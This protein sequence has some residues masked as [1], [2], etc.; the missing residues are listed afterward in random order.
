MNRMYLELN[1]NRR[2]GRLGATVPWQRN[3]EW[4]AI[5]EKNRGPLRLRH[6]SA[7]SIQLATSRL[8]VYRSLNQSAINWQA[9]RQSG[10]RTDHRGG[11]LSLIHRFRFLGD[12]GSPLP[13]DIHFSFG[14]PT[15]LIFRKTTN[16]KRD[17]LLPFSFSPPFFVPTALFS[18]FYLMFTATPFNDAPLLVPRRKG[19]SGFSRKRN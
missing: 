1:Q 19:S 9:V 14:T 7:R 13:A 18:S 12:R 15:K 17:R 11:A 8:P 4:S 2:C 10:K 16:A 6:P 5:G 3:D